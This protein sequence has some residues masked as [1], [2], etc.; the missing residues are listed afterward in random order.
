MDM[1]RVYVS[2]G[3]NVERA[4]HLR[5]G[6]TALSARFGPLMVS[7]I[8]E[9]PAV[10]FDGDP[11]Y[12]CVAA[13]D[14]AEPVDTVHA[15]LHAIEDR[16]GRDRSQPKFS[17][18]TLDL[19]LLLYGDRVMREGR[20][21]LPRPDVDQVAFVLAPLAELAGERVHP[22]RQETFTELWARFEGSDA[23]DLIPVD[24]APLVPPEIL[25]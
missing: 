7:T 8:Y 17:P 23:G 24:P 20:L 3:S 9:C 14:C 5:A 21:V 6:L 25:E 15:E 19:D 2:I 22:A 1:E 16:F 13:F 4:T 12:N 18:R 11:F 10:G